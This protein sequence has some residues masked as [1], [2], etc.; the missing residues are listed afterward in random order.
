MFLS[1]ISLNSKVPNFLSVH[2]S[3]WI[4]EVLPAN[5]KLE[6][7]H[8]KE[9][10]DRLI[11]PIWRIL[12]NEPGNFHDFIINEIKC[13]WF[14]ER[15]DE[16]FKMSYCSEGDCDVIYIIRFPVSERYKSKTISP[17]KKEL[18]LQIFVHSIQNFINFLIS[19]S[20]RWKVAAKL[21]AFAFF[22]SLF[23]SHVC[24]P[25]LKS[26][27]D[28]RKKLFKY[29]GCVFGGCVYRESSARKGVDLRRQRRNFNFN[30]LSTFGI[31]ENGRKIRKKF[32]AE[33]MRMGEEK[34]LN[35]VISVCN[36][37]IKFQRIFYP[38]LLP[39]HISS[40]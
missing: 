36:E 12:L 4:T 33:K 17:S 32:S 10:N 34:C 39:Q 40:R 8:W 14:N 5:V 25:F 22:H 9:A 31:R 19:N 7:N 6:S 26:I 24:F 21:F 13:H 37:Q 1:I 27:I 28:M 16:L 3:W 11:P 23:S 18:S 20:T 30:I 35:N 29:L 15:W 2:P 38:F